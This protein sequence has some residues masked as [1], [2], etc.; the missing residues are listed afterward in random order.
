MSTSDS[1]AD[2]VDLF[3]GAVSQAVCRVYARYYGPQPGQGLQVTGTL[4]GP[5][6]IYAE[7]LPATSRFIDRG[8]GA[9][10]LAE[11]IVPE[12]SFWTP[13]MPHLYQARWQLQQEGR[14]LGEAERCFGIRRFGAA[15]GRLRLDGKAWVLRGVAAAGDRP[16]DPAQWHTLDTAL[17]VAAPDDS[18]CETASRVGVFVVA[19]LD[20]SDADEIRRLSRWPA[21]GIV[22]LPRGANPQLEG[23][24]LNLLLAERFSGDM[25]IT[26]SPWAD[27]VILQV[28]DQEIAGLV[29]GG[30]P[31]IVRRK[32]PNCTSVDQ[33]RAGCDKLQRSLAPQGQFAGYIV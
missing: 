15:G 10:P 26:P 14:V 21:V 33:A 7:T 24:G 30:L 3:F 5:T 12:P 4:T 20:Q 32:L 18:I 8:P 2:C 17:V 9:A 25:P 23:V 16:V 13:E 6:C 22:S 28:S 1:H 19:E 29:A 27:L 31:V 11:A